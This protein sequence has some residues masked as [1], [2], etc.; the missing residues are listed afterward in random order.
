MSQEKGELAKALRAATANAKEVTAFN[1]P[2]KKPG[3]SGDAK[4]TAAKAKAKKKA[5]KPASKGK[6]NK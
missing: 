2:A 1:A 4:K 5:A 6:K 3:K